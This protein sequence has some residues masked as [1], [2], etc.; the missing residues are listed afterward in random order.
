VADAVHVHYLPVLYIPVVGRAL[1]A[2]LYAHAFRKCSDLFERCDAVLGSWLYPDCVAAMTVARETG[3]PCWIRLHG[4]DRFHLDAPVRG[5]QCRRAL[6]A[7]EGVFVNASRMREELVQ[8]DVAE[9]RITLARNG[10]DREL[11][12]P[13]DSLSREQP[14]PSAE[15]TKTILWV[16][17]L[18]GIKGP[19]IA[20]RAFAQM[21]GQQ[22]PV[23][24]LVVVGEGALR[25]ELEGLAHELGV[26][27]HVAFVGSCSHED[28]AE[29]MSRADCLLLSSRSEG[30]PNVVLEALASGTPVVATDV[31]DV[32]AVVRDGVNGR[33]VEANVDGTASLLAEALADVLGG[34]FRAEALRD[35]VADY[36]WQR[37]AQ[38][39]VDAMSGGG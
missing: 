18:L 6:D 38:I 37:S 26:T 23:P 16:G 31:G 33:V 15:G 11:F 21:V 1:S 39:V 8:R 27:E 25:G 36:D 2:A 35:S 9:D 4:T 13:R 7:A 3:K 28:V 17:N 24:R 12:R 19:D 30:M 10:V 22:T 14:T 34:E 32:P 20:L 5:P 29:W